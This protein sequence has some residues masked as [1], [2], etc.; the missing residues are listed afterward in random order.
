MDA[1]K[2]FAIGLRSRL[3]C[4]PSTSNLPVLLQKKARPRTHSAP[5]TGNACGYSSCTHQHN[6][7]FDNKC[8]IP[9]FPANL[10]TLSLG[11]MFDEAAM[12]ELP[13]STMFA[14]NN[15]NNSTNDN[16]D[17]TN[18]NSNSSSNNI[19]AAATPLQP[20]NYVHVSAYEKLIAY[21]SKTLQQLE[22]AMR[23]SLLLEGLT[24]L[25]AIMKKHEDQLSSLVASHFLIR[26]LEQ[27]SAPTSECGGQRSSFF[28]HQH[29]LSQ[30][31]VYVETP[32]LGE[33]RATSNSRGSPLGCSLTIQKSRLSPYPDNN[34]LSST[35]ATIVM[36]D[37]EEPDT[38]HWPWDGID[39]DV[40]LPEYP[41]RFGRPLKTATSEDDLLASSTIIH[42]PVGINDEESITRDILEKVALGEYNRQ[43]CETRKQLM[44]LVNRH[45]PSTAVRVHTDPS[46]G[47]PMKLG[48][49]SFGVVLL[50]DIIKPELFMC[51]AV[52]KDNHTQTAVKL[53]DLDDL[54]EG[55]SEIRDTILNE[56]IVMSNV[57]HPNIV[58]YFG[59]F[60]DKSANTLWCSMEYCRGQSLHDIVFPG[61][62]TQKVMLDYEI[63]K[64]SQDILRSL[65]YLSSKGWVHRDIKLE[66]I[67]S[68]GNN[69]FKLSDFGLARACH[70]NGEI[71]SSLL[72]G[73]LHYLGPEGF[74][75]LHGLITGRPTCSTS[76]RGDVYA[77]GVCV[78][79]MAG[80]NTTRKIVRPESY[81]PPRFKPH[82]YGPD[83]VDLQAKLSS[84]LY[85]FVC[86]CLADD[87]SQRSTAEQL[88]RH[89]FIVSYSAS[90]MLTN[91][92]LNGEAP[93][94]HPHAH[95]LLPLALAQATTGLPQQTDPDD[96]S[97]EDSDCSTDD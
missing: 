40:Q 50:A 56:I 88:L 49:G 69:S 27:P 12:N 34:D 59:T 90:G 20:D 38:P 71:T 85:S 5:P 3:G 87:P 78:L 63:A 53:I 31:S 96:D 7:I 37:E 68:D 66:N 73:T 26:A 93:V 30:G 14:N 91:S 6:S 16:D 35:Q 62:V 41:S 22:T 43:N 45:D 77:F 44:A 47:T 15:N 48:E 83:K 92:S 74:N 84:L 32:K 11:T 29:T 55:D 25:E 57:H 9:Q 61:G 75:S 19:P 79:M 8:Q 18:N 21:T 86:C 58:S 76:H 36:K 42:N 23:E 24:G 95:L 67:L 64:I 70:V 72:E 2:R 97:M 1:R 13:I 81:A 82:C 60:F 89:P 51:D 46:N 33:R 52:T 28:S 65:F 54:E 80:I 4:T 17:N 39:K 10:S 94:P